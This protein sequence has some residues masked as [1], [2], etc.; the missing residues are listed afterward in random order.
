MPLDFN[1][2]RSP[3]IDLLERYQAGANVANQGFEQQN[4]LMDLMANRDMRQLQFQQARAQAERMPVLQQREDFQWQMQQ[5]EALRKQQE[6]Q[7][8]REILSR[9]T[10]EQQQIYLMGGGA[11]LAESMLPER[12]TPADRM[13][14]QMNEWNIKKIQAEL[15]GGVKPQFSPDLGGYVYPPNAQ[16]PQGRFVPV[17][18]AKKPMNPLVEMKMQEKA[19]AKEMAINQQ[20]LSAQQVLDQAATL[21]A[22]PGRQMA[23]GVSSFMSAVPGTDARGFKANLDTFKAQTFVPMVSALKGM[24]ALSDAEGKKLSESVGALD[25]GMSEGEFAHS[26]QTITR[27]LYD[28][29]RAAGLNVQMPEF[30]GVSQRTQ[31]ATGDWS[32][33]QPAQQT[34]RTSTGATV[35]G[36]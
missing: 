15:E 17:E 18:G 32:G 28:K 31:G 12:L 26:L 6:D 30:A 16:N 23:T 36:W 25:P 33:N 34:N 22:H 24:G 9:M 3:N 7:Q 8:K 35:S 29:S 4:R 13:R 2:L 5:A 21:Y 14:Q 19:D 20:S 27:Y 11:K 10:P 1:L